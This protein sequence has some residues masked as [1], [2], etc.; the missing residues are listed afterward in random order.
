MGQ[1]PQTLGIILLTLGAFTYA[2][3]PE[4]ILEFNKRKSLDFVQRQIDKRTKNHKPQPD[5]PVPVPAPA[6]SAGT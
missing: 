6:G 4:G 5:A 1:P 2:K 3:H